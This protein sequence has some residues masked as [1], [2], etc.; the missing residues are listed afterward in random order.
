MNKNNQINKFTRFCAMP[1]CN[2]CEH[3]LCLGRDKRIVEFN[4]EKSSKNAK[5][6][7][8]RLEK[9]IQWFL[10]CDNPLNCCNLLEDISYH[11]IFVNIDE[12][13]N[14]GGNQAKSLYYHIQTSSR[15][16]PLSNRIVFMTG[17]CYFGASLYGQT[18]DGQDVSFI[19]YLQFD[20]KDDDDDLKQLV[21][22]TKENGNHIYVQS[23]MKELCT[24]VKD[25][26][27]IM[28]PVGKDCTIYVHLPT[29]EYVLKGLSFFKKGLIT[30]NAL[31]D[32]LI[33]LGIEYENTSISI[34]S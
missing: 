7:Y 24:A 25:M 21:N 20:F 22:L 5:K 18:V 16:I 17:I 32:F 3:V 23:A 27:E 28:L 33:L 12:F 14:D 34:F 26:K 8:R 11:R 6:L 31:N 29:A 10:N 13:K 30:K 1:N 15:D 9:N 4:Y 19:K 2:Q